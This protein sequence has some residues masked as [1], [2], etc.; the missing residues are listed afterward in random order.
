VAQTVVHYILY[1]ENYFKG[2]TIIFGKISAKIE[3]PSV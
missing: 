1:N 3:H 2:A